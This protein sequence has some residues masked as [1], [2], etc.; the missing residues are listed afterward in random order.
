M[1]NAVLFLTVLTDTESLTNLDTPHYIGLDCPSR[2]IKLVY[3][4]YIFFY[5]PLSLQNLWKKLGAN[6]RGLLLWR[7]DTTEK[8]GLFCSDFS[9]AWPKGFTTQKGSKRFIFFQANVEFQ[10]SRP[11]WLFWE[12]LFLKLIV[13]K[14]KYFKTFSV[15][16]SWHLGKYF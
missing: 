9:E 16:L 12:G 10:V 3:K 6:L 5:A 13:K 7:Y 4:L 14:I 15:D 2:G 8:N 1:Y 11:L